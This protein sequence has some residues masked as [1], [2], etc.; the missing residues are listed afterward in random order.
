MRPVR[1]ALNQFRMEPRQPK[2]FGRR[3]VL[4]ALFL[5]AAD[6]IG[7]RGLIENEK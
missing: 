2:K 3:G 7:P 6:D 1:L 5:G 4:F